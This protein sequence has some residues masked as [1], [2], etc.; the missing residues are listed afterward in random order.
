MAKTKKVKKFGVKIVY[1]VGFG[2]I[3]IPSDV[4]AN[5]KLAE[6]EDEAIDSVDH[7]YELASEWIR[8][9]IKERDCFEHSFEVTD[10]TI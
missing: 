5:L 8:D 2:N 4:L 7:K 3:D 10:L 6:Q 9:N 1:K